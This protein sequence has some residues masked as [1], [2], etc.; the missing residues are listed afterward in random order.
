[1]TLCVSVP[2]AGQ[3]TRN[4]KTWLQLEG[5]QQ[6]HWGDKACAHRHV[7]TVRCSRWP[8]SHRWCVFHLTSARTVQSTVHW[9]SQRFSEEVGL[10]GA[11]EHGLDVEVKNRERIV[12]VSL[13]WPYQCWICWYPSIQPI[14]KTPIVIFPITLSAWHKFRQKVICEGKIQV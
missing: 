9:S 2:M 14:K 4:W 11:H 12:L 8:M 3:K 5:S 10:H 13:P 1:M 7:N 6:F